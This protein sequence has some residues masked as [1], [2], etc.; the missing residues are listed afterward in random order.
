MEGNDEE[1]DA[2][3]VWLS[4]LLFPR[5]VSFVPFVI[6]ATSNRNSL[7]T[8]IAYDFQVLL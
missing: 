2:L 6:N 4:R 8:T 7:L 1:G 5:H 3:S